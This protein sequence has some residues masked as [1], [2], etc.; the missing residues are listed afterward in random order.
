V[1]RHERWL[2]GGRGEDEDRAGTC[3][4]GD[5]GRR[6]ALRFVGAISLLDAVRRRDIDEGQSP[7]SVMLAAPLPLAVSPVTV[8]VA[9][10]SARL[11]AE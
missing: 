3:A 4:A 10:W 2:M 7:R 5:R 6:R 11:T 1:S 8:S 9:E